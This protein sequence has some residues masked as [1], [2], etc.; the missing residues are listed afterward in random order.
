MTFSDITI[1][2][3]FAGKEYKRTLHG[4]RPFAAGSLTLVS[5]WVCRIMARLFNL[6]YSEN[7]KQYN[8]VNGE[9]VEAK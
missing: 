4:L 1:T 6:K 3:S 9:I 8:L 7:K 2:V 5:R